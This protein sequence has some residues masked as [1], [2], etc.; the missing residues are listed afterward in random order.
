MEAV[1]VPVPTAAL[2]ALAQASAED[3][4]RAAAVQE[5]AAPTP[6]RLVLTAESL[7]GGDA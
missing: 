6:A 4:L 1:E 7:S 3:K 5:V 2:V